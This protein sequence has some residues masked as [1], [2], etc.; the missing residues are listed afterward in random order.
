MRT[1]PLP[2]S[3]KRRGGLK[4]EE[5]SIV[6]CPLSIV[7]YPL[8]IA[9][10]PLPPSLSPFAISVFCGVPVTSL[11]D[12]HKPMAAPVR[13]PRTLS[14]LKCSASA[15]SIITA[16]RSAVIIRELTRQCQL[17]CTPFLP[18]LKNFASQRLCVEINE[19]KTL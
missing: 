4:I 18:N 3:P 8:S 5:F 14:S 6:H 12:L 15:S 2:T 17:K 7:H 10:Y 1:D 13:F 9:H 16:P 19:V 11:R